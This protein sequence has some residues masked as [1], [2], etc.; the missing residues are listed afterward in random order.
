MATLRDI[1]TRI[2][3]VRQ[4]RKITSAMKMVSV[5]K[6]RRHQ[7]R[8]RQYDPFRASFTS[9]FTDF[10]AAAEPK[11]F[12]LLSPRPGA[13]G[14]IVLVVTAERG[15][16][17]SYNHGIRRAAEGFLA[18]NEGPAR[19]LVTGASNRKYFRGRGYDLIE[20][21]LPD[22][23]RQRALAVGDLL[24][25][26]FLSGASARVLAVCDRLDLERNRGVHLVEL[27]PLA[28]PEGSE[29]SRRL[30]SYMLEGGFGENFKW[31]CEF[32]LYTLIYGL[33][34]DAA[35]GEESSRMNAMDLATRNADDLIFDLTLSY[36]KAR[37]E[38]ITLELLDIVGG[39]AGE[40]SGD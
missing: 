28:A 3:S 31:I 5:A 38:A 19:L 8:Q 2:R 37:Q 29:P 27:L 20:A 39:S 36:N 25:E 23:L 4:I 9:L 16:C 22:S 15:L 11:E 34:L 32:Y 7:Q 40:S 33:L 13:E 26:S 35:A 6:L 18:G 17:G 30:G 12:P 14:V 1:K 24:R 21:E 10:V